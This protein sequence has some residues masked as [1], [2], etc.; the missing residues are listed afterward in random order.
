VRIVEQAVIVTSA[1]VFV[2]NYTGGPGVSQKRF[3]RTSVTA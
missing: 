1:K 2:A 3:A